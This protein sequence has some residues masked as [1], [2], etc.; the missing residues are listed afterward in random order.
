MWRKPGKFA[1]IID[2]SLDYSEYIVGTKIEL[3]DVWIAIGS[4]DVLQLGTSGEMEV[5]GNLGQLEFSIVFAP[6]FENIFFAFMTNN[7][8]YV[9]DY[10]CLWW[11][12]WPQMTM[13]RSNGMS[14]MHHGMFYCAI[15]RQNRT[16]IKLLY[17]VIY[18]FHSA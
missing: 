5:T 15:Y 2:P 4:N 6:E 12:F 10:Q 1:W 7:I 3:S 13:L 9:Y 16:G 17:K 14:A 11:K 8:K 18:S